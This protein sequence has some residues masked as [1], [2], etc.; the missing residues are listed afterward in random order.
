MMIRFTGVPST[1]GGTPGTTT[2]CRAS[3]RRRRPGRRRRRKQLDFGA[4]IPRDARY[5]DRVGQ[6]RKVAILRPSEHWRGLASASDCILPSEPRASSRSTPCATTS[7]SQR[8]RPASAFLPQPACLLRPSMAMP[9]HTSNMN[10][11]AQATAEAAQLLFNLR[12]RYCSEIPLAVWQRVV[13]RDSRGRSGRI[14]GQICQMMMRC[15]GHPSPRREPKGPG[16]L[17]YP[18]HRLTSSAAEGTRRGELLCHGM[19]RA[20]TAERGRGA[21]DISRDELEAR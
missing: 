21:T 14:S 13:S 8:W 2:I 3:W 4:A 17:S 6:P 18:P 19:R 5:R 1:A 7:T 16:D 11:H 20:A 9:N 15:T 12:L 10:I